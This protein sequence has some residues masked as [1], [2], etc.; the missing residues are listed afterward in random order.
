[1]QDPEKLKQF[2][3]RILK[4][5]KELNK[6]PRPSSPYN[7]AEAF[8]LMCYQSDDGR[9]IE[10]IWNSR[11]GVTPFIVLTKDGSKTMQHID[12]HRDKCRPHHELQVGDRYFADSTRESLSKDYDKLVE[13]YKGT[14]DFVYLPA[15]EQWIDE[16]L[17]SYLCAVFIK[18]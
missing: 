15:K 9:V 6:K 3:D 8:C 2:S 17:T 18:E 1:M 16:A 12:W 11:D 5:D 10:Y 4:L 14:P 13:M 7:H